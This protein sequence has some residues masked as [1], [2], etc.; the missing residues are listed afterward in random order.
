MGLG[1][2][3]NCT[4][5][6]RIELLPSSHTNNYFKQTQ[7]VSRLAV[8]H[9]RMTCSLYS[10][11]R[12]HG[13]C[14]CRLAAPAGPCRVPWAAAGP[15]PRCRRTRPAAPAMFPSPVCHAASRENQ[16][17]SNAIAMQEDKWAAPPFETIL[18]AYATLVQSSLDR[19][20]KGVA[21]WTP[22]KQQDNM[23]SRA[24]DSG[25]AKFERQRHGE[26]QATRK[27]G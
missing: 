8:S 4:I 25:R 11:R 5:Q 20:E 14:E 19:L 23:P 13:P 17:Y 2:G 10:L 18:R 15:R 1:I 3:C 9:V 27:Q 22:R 7:H 12:Q 24:E 16:T 26:T 6:K 21:M